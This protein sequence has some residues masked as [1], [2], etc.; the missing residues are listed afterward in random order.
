M[1]HDVIS[2]K[3]A[4]E[5]WEGKLIPFSGPQCHED[6]GKDLY[7]YNPDI[8]MSLENLKATKSVTEKNVGSHPTYKDSPSVI[9]FNGICQ[10]K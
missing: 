4:R 1:T 5:N 2:R 8:R 6:R 10:Q 3:L 9:S 7:E